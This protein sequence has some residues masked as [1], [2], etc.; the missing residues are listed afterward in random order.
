MDRRT[1]LNVFSAFLLAQC[2][3]AT[4]VVRAFDPTASLMNDPSGDALGNHQRPNTTHHIWLP[5]KDWKVLQASLDRFS[6]IQAHVGFGNFCLMGFDDSLKVARSYAKVGAFTHQEVD[7]LDQ[8]FHT[9]ATLYGFLGEKN[10]HNMSDSVAESKIQKIPGTGNYLFKGLPQKYYQRISHDIGDQVVLTAGIR[11][12]A[13]QFYLFLGKIIKT[14]G[15]ISLASQ[16]IAPPG[17]SYHGIGDFDVG[18]VGFGVANF[19]T[20][21]SRTKVYKKLT[22]LDYI[23]FRYPQ[24]NRLGVLFEPWHIQ[25]V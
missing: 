15:N 25:V 10:F 20:R 23:V 5:K 1:F 24:D 6:R 13:K 9:D 3:P 18:Q 4:R 19:S 11:G 12:M 16:S 21:F 14:S 7:F 22:Q 17:Y 2:L 8:L